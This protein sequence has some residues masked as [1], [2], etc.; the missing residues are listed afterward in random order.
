MK[1]HGSLGILT[2][3]F[4]HTCNSVGPPGGGHIDSVNKELD[5]VIMPVVWLIWGGG[6]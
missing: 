5:I 4:C 1:V 6:W 2:K 3:I